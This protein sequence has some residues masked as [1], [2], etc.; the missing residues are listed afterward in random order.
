MAYAKSP[1]ARQNYLID[2]LHE[3]GIVDSQTDRILHLATELRMGKG[4]P[5]KRLESYLKKAGKYKR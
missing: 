2:A 1:M 3:A 4:T 5:G